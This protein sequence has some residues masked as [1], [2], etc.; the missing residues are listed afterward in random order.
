M[1]NQDL[2]DLNIS[3]GGKFQESNLK[4]QINLK[5]KLKYHAL[6][7][8]PIV[9]LLLIPEFCGCAVMFGLQFSNCFAAIYA[10]VIAKTP[11]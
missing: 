8:I 9:K 6:I 3:A 7:S 10:D 4:N 1:K 5:S 2:L 11:T